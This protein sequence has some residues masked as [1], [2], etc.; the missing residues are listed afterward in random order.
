MKA[1]T[2]TKFAAPL[3][4]AV[5]L[6]W[7]CA[8][9][10]E[11]PASRAADISAQQK[12]I[13]E[14]FE[15]L[16]KTMAKLSTV[17]EKTDPDSARALKQAVD[18]A[19]SAFIAEDMEKVVEYINKGL[20][21]RADK[22]E[23]DVI[24]NLQAVLEAL[25]RGQM[26]PEKWDEII[27]GM[28]EALAKVQ[29]LKNQEANLSRQNAASSKTSADL[30]A[31]VGKQIEQLA[32]EQKELMDATAGA[33]GDP[34]VL[35]LMGLL[36]DVRALMD[37]Q[38]KVSRESRAMAIDKL[39]LAGAVQGKLAEE[40]N[41][42]AKKADETAKDSALAGAIAGAGADPN[43]V[44]KAGAYTGD[45]GA[46]MKKAA[47][48]LN[49]SEAS[50]AERPQDN[51]GGNLGAAE[52][53]L[54]A[55]I[56][57]MTKNTRSGELLKRQQ[58]LEN[59]AAELAK[60][61]GELAGSLGLGEPKPGEGKASE[62]RPSESRPSG[63]KPAGLQNNLQKA[64]DAMAQAGAEL[65]QEDPNK[66]LPHQAEALKN[67]GDYKKYELAQIRKAVEAK[68]RDPNEMARDQGALAKKADALSEQMKN[69]ATKNPD[70][71]PT[72]GQQSV[73]NAKG[74]MDEAA[75]K[76]GQGKQDDAQGDQQKAIEEL[77][78]AE[79]DLKK[80]I[81]EAEKAKQDQQLEKIEEKL[82]K[83]LSSQQNISAETT[84][85]SQKALSAKP[86]DK[87]ELRTVELKMTKELS[88]GEGELGDKIQ[89]ILDMLKKENATVVFPATLEMVKKDL[90]DTRDRLARKDAGVLT[91]AI[92]KEIEQN[93]EAMIK[94]IR[95]TLVDRREKKKGGGGGGGGGGKSPLVPPVAELK[96]LVAMQ[97]QINSRTTVL[98]EQSAGKTLPAD[99]ALQQHK[100][101]S[102]REANVKKLTNDTIKKL[103]P[104]R[105]PV[106][107][108]TGE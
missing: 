27:A 93:L 67:L 12:I 47:A 6:A 30:A 87:A 16:I 18:Q 63:S 94:S 25:R 88:P 28:K 100:E 73:S 89:E 32:K 13:K 48:A 84:K 86:E 92:Q 54:A 78:K 11:A 1:G 90:L 69:A 80:A 9:A 4:S 7:A 79:D 26:S 24:K 53:A 10:Q 29:E 74:N 85:A 55:T 68:P 19:Q 103:T 59:K 31:D 8:H 23:G 107:E 62:S 35:K 81:D 20:S 99:Q 83:I 34:N 96:M 36:N 33:S 95:D 14:R 21:I 46:E 75:G 66:A 51:A 71:K 77:A 5:A 76:M 17:L 57:K 3:L 61:A 60:K 50:T 44:A 82:A 37:K 101:L 15:G 40:A 72:P 2:I 41:Q 42:I 108:G 52:K 105:T 91:Q 43:A 106:N 38:G 49:K 56:E 45:A 39:P 104:E 98:A 22:V 64:A 70:G 58:E 97:R 65:G 102:Q